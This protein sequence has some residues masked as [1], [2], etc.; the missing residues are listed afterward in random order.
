MSW[1]ETLDPATE[2]HLNRLLRRTQDYEEAYSGF[3]GAIK[4]LWVALALLSQDIAEIQDELRQ[5]R[6]ESQ[7]AKRP[8]QTLDSELQAS[9]ESY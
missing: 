7:S 3:N 4:Q 2:S 9:I 8:E 6:Q 1:H 5:L